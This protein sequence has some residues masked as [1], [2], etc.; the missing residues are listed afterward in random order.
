MQRSQAEHR[1]TPSD[2]EQPG[3]WYETTTFI[4]FLRYVVTVVPIRRV[5]RG[6]RFRQNVDRNLFRSP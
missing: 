6:A 5:A 2:G 4:A 1:D 3:G